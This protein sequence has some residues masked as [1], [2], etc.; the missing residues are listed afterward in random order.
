MTCTTV[1]GKEMPLD[2][3]WPKLRE[4][5]CQE[6]VW[7]DFRHYQCSRRISKDQWCGQHHPDAIAARR[8]KGKERYEKAR[9]EEIARLT[10]YADEALRSENAQLI[11]EV[12]YLVAELARAEDMLIEA[13]KEWAERD[14]N[15]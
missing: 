8:K 6:R 15:G 4:G 10:S 9:R 3:S 7:R 5:Y 12:E 11:K 1:K 13:H 14:R 2:G